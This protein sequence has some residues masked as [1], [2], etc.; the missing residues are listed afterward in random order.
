[1]L[2]SGNLDDETERRRRWTDE[3]DDD[4][5]HGGHMTAAGANVVS[6]DLNKIKFSAGILVADL[7]CE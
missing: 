3:F 2:R 7:V 4:L 5:V 1:M 6:G